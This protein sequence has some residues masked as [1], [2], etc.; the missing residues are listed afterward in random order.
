M[1]NHSHYLDQ[2]I[3]I[4][5]AQ[6]CDELD[7]LYT[8]L[9][10]LNRKQL[11][12]ILD[13]ADLIPADLDN[14]LDPWE[15]VAYQ[16]DSAGYVV[17]IEA[18]DFSGETFRVLKEKE[19]K[20]YGEYL[21]YCTC[22]IVL[23]GEVINLETYVPIKDPPPSNPS[24]A[25]PLRNESR[26]EGPGLVIGEQSAVSRERRVV[27]D[28]KVEHVAVEVEEEELI[29]ENKSVIQKKAADASDYCL[30]KFQGCGQMVLGFDMEKH[31]RDVHGGESQE[32]VG[33]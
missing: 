13:H 32:F 33:L 26:Y 27:R 1:M 5:H 22:N 18:S 16:I 10:G 24:V 31:V 2:V 19:I 9:Y 7:T 4:H 21:E 3:E 11:R 6:L 12:Y 8:H 20:Q 30:Y 29:P 17:R 28:E 23:A 25:H 15:E 14:I